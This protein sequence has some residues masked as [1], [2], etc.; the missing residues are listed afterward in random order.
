[1]ALPIAP[2]PP[3]EGPFVHVVRVT[4]GDCDP[5]LIA[6]TGRI[7]GYALEAIDAWWTHHIGLD[8]YRLN[9][10]HGVST[11]FV[12]LDVDF[13]A[14]ITPRHPLD[15]VVDLLKLGTGSVTFSVRGLQDGRLCFES[16]FVC[17]FVETRTFRKIPIPPEI[18]VAVQHRVRPAATPSS[19]GAAGEP[20]IQGH[21]ASGSGR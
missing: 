21:D 19:R 18:R 11:P 1:M 15:C 17:T 2:P 20:G 5:A 4:W 6:Y 10:D 9:V 7:P 12:H 3:S 16:R 13:R 14:T 8:W